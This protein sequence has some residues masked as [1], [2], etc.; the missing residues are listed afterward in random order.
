MRHAVV[1]APLLGKGPRHVLRTHRSH[2]RAR[3]PDGWRMRRQRSPES[4]Q[5]C[6]TAK[7]HD[8]PVSGNASI[9]SKPLPQSWNT[10]LPALGVIMEE[11][12]AKSEVEDSVRD[13]CFTAM[14]SISAKHALPEFV[15]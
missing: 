9:W 7:Q 5:S 4:E 14:M 3:P 8:T 15:S 11:R 12:L 2:G 13:S 6:A 10:Q 1:V